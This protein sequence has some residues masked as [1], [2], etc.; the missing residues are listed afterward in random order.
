MEH[1]RII[2]DRVVKE[3]EIKGDEFSHRYFESVKLYSFQEI[4]NVFKTFGFNPIKKFGSYNSDI[5]SE[6]S[7]ERMIII[8]KRKE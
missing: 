7:S 5:F 6:N 4:L 1:R 2:N 3:I 8:F